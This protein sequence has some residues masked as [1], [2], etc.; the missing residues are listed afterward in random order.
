MQTIILPGISKEDKN[1]V[2]ET[3]QKLKS[4]GVEGIIRPFYWM[5]WTDDSQK[6]DLQEKAELIAKHLRGEKVNII[7][8][9]EG[10]EI[11]NVLKTLIPNQILTVNSD[12]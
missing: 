5:H 2:D 10:L 1:W 7:A 8:K 6:F 11:A 4:E 3:A 12:I 9:N